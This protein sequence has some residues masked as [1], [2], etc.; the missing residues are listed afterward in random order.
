MTKVKQTTHFTHQ[1]DLVRLL[2]LL[3][4]LIS[5]ALESVVYLTLFQVDHRCFMTYLFFVV[6]KVLD[7]TPKFSLRFTK[8]LIFHFITTCCLCTN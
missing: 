7:E 3:E 5:F 6:V 4:I 2:F 8:N 1:L